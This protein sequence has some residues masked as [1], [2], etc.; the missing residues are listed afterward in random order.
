MATLFPLIAPSRSRARSHPHRLRPSSSWGDI[1]LYMLFLTIEGSSFCG[2]GR[3]QMTAC[4]AGGGGGFSKSTTTSRVMNNFLPPWTAVWREFPCRSIH[5][6]VKTRV[7]HW[8]EV[9]VNNRI[10]HRRYCQK[11]P[12]SRNNIIML[13][14]TLTIISEIKWI[15]LW[16]CVWQSNLNDITKRHVAFEKT[17]KKQKKT[18]YELARHSPKVEALMEKMTEIWINHHVVFYRNCKPDFLFRCFYQ[19][20]FVTNEWLVTSKKILLIFLFKSFF[21]IFEIF[22]LFKLSAW[23]RCVNEFWYV[24]L[25]FETIHQ[26][27]LKYIIS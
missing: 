27:F 19:A 23:L 16:H 25:F 7:R 15:G 10:F 26:M 8:T 11:P 20:G 17:S 3:V 22:F 18:R 6:D 12:S 9:S 5:W 1:C 2:R 21:L 13:I 14:N 24:V 4:S